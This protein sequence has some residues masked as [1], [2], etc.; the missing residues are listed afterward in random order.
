MHFVVFSHLSVSFVRLCVRLAAETSLQQSCQHQN[1]GAAVVKTSEAG[2]VQILLLGHRLQHAM[3]A[4]CLVWER[5]GASRD[6]RAFAVLGFY[7]R[8]FLFLGTCSL[9]EG[10]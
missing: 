6:I 4:E 1:L 5:R 9:Q 2:R 10:T 8:V 7:S 3:S